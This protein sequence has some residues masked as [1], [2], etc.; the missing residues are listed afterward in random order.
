[1]SINRTQQVDVEGRQ[2][3]VRRLLPEI[4]SFIWQRLMAAMV[5]ASA[6]SGFKEDKPE[7]HKK[8]KKEQNK[9]QEIRGLCGVA[10][11]YLE[12][13]EFAFIQS[14]CMRV[15]SR[16]ENELPMPVMSDRGQWAAEDI[17]DNP[18]LVTKLVTEVLA[19]NLVGF[20][21]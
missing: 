2:Y 9:D 15:L 4:G 20:L 16:F 10:F 1:M 21:G 6:Q 14:Q 5:R 7:E 3:Q 18:F 13:E 19:F 17:A 11:M 8:H 12:F